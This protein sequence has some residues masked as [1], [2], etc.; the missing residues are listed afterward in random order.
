MLAFSVCSLYLNKI[1]PEGATAIAKAL[2]VNRVLTSLNLYQNAIGD[3]GA[4]AIAKALEVNAV[5]TNPKK[6]IA[7]TFTKL[8]VYFLCNHYPD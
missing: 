7:S 1:G 3:E 8:T 4:A 2:E 5:L 6:E